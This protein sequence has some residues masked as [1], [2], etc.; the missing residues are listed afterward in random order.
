M[1]ILNKIIKEKENEVAILKGKK[2]TSN[3]S[4]EIIPFSEKI[5]GS[6]KMN[7][8]AEI[9]RSSPSKG[10]IQMEV[11]PVTQAKEYE[12]L[13]ASAISVLTDSPFFNGSMQDLIAVREAVSLPILCKDFMIDPIQI[14]QA[15]AAGATI[16]LL[17]AAALDH[18]ALTSMYKYAQSLD[19]EVL[20]EVHDEDE[21]ERALNLEATMI[22]INNRNLKTFE[23][24]LET[25]AELASMVYDPETVVVSESGI[26]TREDV[27]GVEKA[28]AQ[29]VLIG[30]TLMRSTNLPKT[31]GDLQIPL[32]KKEG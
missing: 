19:L 20:V 2:F 6:T 21:M 29:V 14:D 25:T 12:R 30:E 23:V 13:G 9:K 5:S 27:I 1:T 17:I 8:I 7:I 3:I 28:G 24:D 10:A 26:R 15:K 32:H 31:F 16:I 11:D 22:G 18:Q 4:G